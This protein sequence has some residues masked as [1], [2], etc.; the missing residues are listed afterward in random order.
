MSVYIGIFKII[1]RVSNS[2]VQWSE[3]SLL[4]QSSPIFQL[5]SVAHVTYHTTMANDLT[6]LVLLPHAWH[7]TSPIKN[8]KYIDSSSCL[9]SRNRGYWLSYMYSIIL[10]GESVSTNKIGRPDNVALNLQYHIV[11]T[12]FRLQNVFLFILG[13]DHF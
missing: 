7:L 4:W 13:S 10:V 11:L 6:R 5:T 3:N 2:A 12:H 1:H 8:R 9:G